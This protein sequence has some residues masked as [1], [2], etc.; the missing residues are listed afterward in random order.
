[1]EGNNNYLIAAKTAILLIIFL[2]GLLGIYSANGLYADG[3]AFLYTIL[4][5]KSFNDFDKP[6]EFAQL[7]TQAPVVMAVRFNVLDITKLIY[8]HS[9]GLVGIPVLI[10]ISALGQHIKTEYFWT[11]LVAYSATHLTSGFFSAGEY[12]L[13]YALTALCFALINKEKPSALSSIALI[14]SAFA[15]TLTY[16]A[17]AFLGPMLFV[18]GATKLLN[19][20]ENQSPIYRISLVVACFFFA[21]SS[22]IAVWSIIFPR[23]PANM[24]GAANVA[25]LI[26]SNHFIYLAAMIFIF[27]ISPLFSKEFRYLICLVP[28]VLG[29]TYILDSSFWNSPEKNYAF[30]SL[31]GLILFLVLSYAMLASA[32]SQKWPRREGSDLCIITASSILF[33]TLAAPMAIQTYHFSVWIKRF[34]KTVT[35][36]SNWVHIDR[37]DDYT[38]SGYH[39][40]FIWGWSNPVLSMVLKGSNEGGTLNSSTWKGWEPF[41][42]EE[43]TI[44][45]LSYFKK[46]TYLHIYA[47]NN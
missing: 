27:F 38:K 26:E 18:L 46:K 8:F 39:Q 40:E 15:I 11:L 2:L 29:G 32:I 23:D 28:I 14:F 47:P 5:T 17:T 42:V 37:T 3:S 36:T 34:E 10:W 33:A 1:M 16:E 25:L 45:P 35:N 41:K 30:R 22:A 7:I 19:S 12:N 44:N 4:T 43:M 24:A 20:D 13:T 31:S 6:R 9:I 21:A